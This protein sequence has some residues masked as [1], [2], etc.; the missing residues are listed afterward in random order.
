VATQNPSWTVGQVLHTSGTIANAASVQDDFNISTLAYYAI[1]C[2]VDIDIASG[3][4]AGNVTIEVFHSVDGGTNVDTTAAQTKVLTFTGTG[5]QKTSFLVE[6]HPWA[7]VKVGNATTV[8]C[9]YVGRYAGVK[10]VSA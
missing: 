8:T 7:R 6:G 2:Q 9:T 5:N 10:Q 1:D 3:S 4:P